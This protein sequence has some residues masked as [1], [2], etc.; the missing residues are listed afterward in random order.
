[1]SCA[2][3][4]LARSFGPP[5]RHLLFVGQIAGV[6]QRGQHH[7]GHEHDRQHRAAGQDPS[8]ALDLG[9]G[10]AVERDG[11]LVVKGLDLWTLAEDQT[12]GE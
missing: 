3:R 2:A 12:C 10:V 1:M 5:A 6:A 4:R 7:D 9:L 8:Q 11:D